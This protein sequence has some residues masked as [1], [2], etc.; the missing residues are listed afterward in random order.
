VLL[1]QT[2]VVGRGLRREAAVLSAGLALITLIVF[3]VRLRSGEAVDFEPAE[4]SQFALVGL[5]LPF[6]VWKGEKPFEG[7][8]LWTL[9]VDRRRHALLKVLAGGLWFLLAVLLFQLWLLTLALL[10]GGGVGADETRMLASGAGGY[11]PVRWTTPAWEWLAPFTAGAV[12]YALGSAFVLGVRRPVRT[13]VGLA[14]GLVILLALSEEVFPFDTF[15][16]M[17][18]AVA[19]GPFGLDAMLSGGAE[20]LSRDVRGAGGRAFVGWTGLPSA[21]R[22]AGATTLWTAGAGAALFTAL[23]RHREH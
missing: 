1:E 10:T 3:A 21:E 16:T 22:W 5:L 19:M 4:T 17:M 23:F 20:S 9:P 6:A 2:R 8:Y 7:G 11:R 14:V 18:D 12:L 13:A 15:E